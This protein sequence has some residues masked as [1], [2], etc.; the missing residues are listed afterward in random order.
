MAMRDS[1]WLGASICAALLDAG[2]RPKG[3]FGENGIRVSGN[4]IE[5]GADSP[6][7]GTAINQV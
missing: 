7:F 2:E 5:Y 6:M 1:D 3:R 4:A